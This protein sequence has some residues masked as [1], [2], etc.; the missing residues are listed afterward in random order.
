ML[1]TIIKVIPVWNA[2]RSVALCFVMLMR[3]LIQIQAPAI[4]I[5][6]SVCRPLSSHPSPR[7]QAPPFVHRRWTCVNKSLRVFQAM[8]V[9]STHPLNTSCSRSVMSNLQRFV[10]L[11]FYFYFFGQLDIHKQDGHQSRRGKT[12]FMRT[13]TL[14]ELSFIDIF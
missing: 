1:Q 5:C 12:V 9:K 11:L 2:S 10:R 7:Q 6:Q 8:R 4:L 3:K 14:H 13:E